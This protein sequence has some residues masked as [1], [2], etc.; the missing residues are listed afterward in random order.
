MTFIL[1]SAKWNQLVDKNFLNQGL[2]KN[3]YYK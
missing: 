3:M 1:P 2:S